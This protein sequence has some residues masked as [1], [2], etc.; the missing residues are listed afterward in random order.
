MEELHTGIQICTLGTKCMVK[1]IENYLDNSDDSAVI[2]LV[3][4]DKVELGKLSCQLS[5]SYCKGQPL[6]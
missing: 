4:F 5:S 3:E 1:D 6:L 2:Y